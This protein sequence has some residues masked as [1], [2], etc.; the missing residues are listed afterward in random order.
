MVNISKL[1]PP[2][3]TTSSKLLYRS[4]EA[5]SIGNVVDHSHST[6]SI[7]ETVGANLHSGAAL[8]LAEGAASGVVFVVA[9]LVVAVTVV[10]SLDSAAASV[11]DVGGGGGDHGEEDEEL[12][13]WFGWFGGGLG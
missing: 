8:L 7:S 9:E 5:K 13:C 12:H 10:G 6:I 11:D 3:S 1:K 4:T 2:S